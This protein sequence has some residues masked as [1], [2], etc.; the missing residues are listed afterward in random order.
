S[1]DV[2]TDEDNNY[3]VLGVAL[4]PGNQFFMYDS[5]R[6]FF[7][8]GGGHCYIVSVGLYQLTDGTANEVDAGNEND[9]G[10]SPGLRVGLK[11]LE[12]F[13]EPTIILFPDAALLPDDDDGKA[14]FYSLQQMAVS[15][16]AKLQDRVALLDLREAQTN[17]VSEA[18]SEFRDN[19]GIN[20]LKYAA[21]YT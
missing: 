19:I 9:P 15:Q 5:L 1:I 18:V 17:S 4:D 13:D 8:N 11:E 20:N 3:A 6:L 21:A 14:A 10:N 7:D 16:S 12:K 2:I